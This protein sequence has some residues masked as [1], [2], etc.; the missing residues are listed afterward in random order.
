MNAVTQLQDALDDLAAHKQRT[1]CQGDDRDAWT[2]DDSNDL[3]WAAD[4]CRNS[5]PL[6]QMCRAA[7]NETEVEWGAWGGQIYSRKTWDLRTPEAQA[8]RLL[9]MLESE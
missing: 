1:P 5:C 3:A 4:V 6:I 9:R 8:L 2:S 7:A